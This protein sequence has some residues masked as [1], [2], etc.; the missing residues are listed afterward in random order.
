MN[1]VEKSIP[2]NGTGDWVLS[3]YGGLVILRILQ[4][5]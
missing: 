5:G 4:A 1:F 3:Q 2:L